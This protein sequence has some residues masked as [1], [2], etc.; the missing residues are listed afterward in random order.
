MRIYCPVV[1]HVAPAAKE[2]TRWMRGNT[3]KLMVQQN[4]G[5]TYLYPVNNINVTVPNRA[6]ILF[7]DKYTLSSMSAYSTIAG[8]VTGA[9]YGLDYVKVRHEC[10]FI[11]R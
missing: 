1:P 6:V 7:S 8:I 10:S 9:D 4:M 5:T 11:V 2:E 3:G